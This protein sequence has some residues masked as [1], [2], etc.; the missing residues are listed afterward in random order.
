[1]TLLPGEKK[2]ITIRCANK[3]VPQA[4][5]VTLDGW[6]ITPTTLSFAK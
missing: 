1:M 3:D 2:T 4:M 6:N 5:A